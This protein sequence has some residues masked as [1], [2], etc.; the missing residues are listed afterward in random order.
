MA[1]SLILDPAESGLGFVEFDLTPWVR[2]EPG[3]DWG[4]AAIAAYMADQTYGS[5]VVDF[6]VPNRNISVPLVLRSRTG[7]SFDQIRSMVQAKVARWQQE[8]GAIKRI[9]SAGGVVFADVIN[10]SLQLPGSWSQ[11]WKD[12]DV[13]AELTIET[14]P[15]FYE[16]E[17]ALTDHVETTLPE[18]IFT[19]LNIRGDYPGRVRWVVDDDQGQAQLGLIWGVR[20]RN[21]TAGTTA[22]LAYEAE[23]MTPLDT[24]TRA[25]LTGA[26]GGTV[27]THGTVATNW[28]P[29]LN[30][31]LPG[32]TFLTHVGRYRWFVRYRTTSGT[33]V[34][35]R[36]VYDVGD[37]IYPEENNTFYHPASTAGT[38]FYIA[39]LG[40]IQLTR[41]PIGT[42][43]WQGQVQ[44]K[45]A[46]GNENVSLDRIWFQPIDEFAG[47]LRAP[48]STD[49]GLAT[50]SLRDE[51]LQTAGSLSGK[52]LSVGGNWG[53]AGDTEDFA[54][55]ASTHT[56]IRSAVSDSP[57]GWLGR[58]AL[59]G[60]TNFT[61]ISCQVDMSQSIAGHVG[62]Q[63]VLLHYTDTSN[64]VAFYRLANLVIAQKMLAGVPTSL[65]S[66]SSIPLPLLGGEWATI[67]GVLDSRG[68]WYLLYGPQG[69][70]KLIDSGL[71][72][73]L[74]TGALA[75]GRCVLYDEDAQSFAVTRSYDNFA[76]YVPGAD[77][78]INAS[79]S[80]EIRT[81]GVFRED[82]TGSAFSPA[83]W[84]EGDLPR[85]PVAGNEGRVVQVFF[86][87]SRGDLDTL[88]DTN[89]DD[90]SSKGY[91][92]PCWLFVPGA[93]S[94]ALL[95]PELWC[96]PETL[97]GPGILITTWDNE[98]SGA[99]MVLPGGAT[100]PTV[101]AAGIDGFKVVRFD[102][103]T[104][105][106]TA[107]LAADATRTI[108]VVA[109][110][111]SFTANDVLIEFGGASARLRTTTGP[112]WQWATNEAAANVNL[113]GNADA[114]QL[115]TL[116]I[117]SAASMEVFINGV[118]TVS[119][120]PNDS[121]TTGTL[122]RLGGSNGA[123][124]WNGDVPE[125]L[126]CDRL[127]DANLSKVFGYFSRR[128]PTLGSFGT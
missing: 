30:T 90:I 46:V 10:A 61:D 48:T 86:K 89:I 113:G 118:A 21:Y 40:E 49:I 128:Y 126:A 124:W 69:N 74:T 95:A 15:E 121:I 108:F 6:R 127:S 81:D 8:G 17:V 104:N 50:Y 76:A 62:R 120:D 85:L 52:T 58:Y 14:L 75:S 12:Y 29:V 83:S 22:L 11:A 18:I 54:I 72:P 97:P 56:A 32:N 82:S 115:I 122:L 93:F 38:S 51:F 94:P 53:S 26:S 19:E 88:P 98:G 92:K 65:G 102:G 117:N 64:F 109:K 70:P 13:A 67:R 45:G 28:T 36:G 59:A 25:A 31:N 1:E 20:S 60:A 87:G 79:Q 119:L 66:T 106:L 57:V 16:A 91:Y 42:H 100:T 44:S 110:E 41:V 77:S 107:T 112:I 96:R 68:R 33:A 47:V 43:R 125:I 84:V 71:D 2:A 39:D 34:A 35:L 4:D 3:I 23:L 80:A 9:T 5:S 24:A 63:G 101:A 116:R 55:D 78:V 99:D 111:N 7:T 73:G 103:V 37:L 27:V 114:F 105:E 123:L